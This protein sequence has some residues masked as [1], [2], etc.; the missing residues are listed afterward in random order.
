MISDLDI[1]SAVR[2]DNQPWHV[3]GTLF[4]LQLKLLSTYKI[5]PLFSH[6]FA[7]AIN[8][9]IIINNDSFLSLQSN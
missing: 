1:G 8:T 9:A 4:Y 2:E 3:T 5:H 6:Q 7:S